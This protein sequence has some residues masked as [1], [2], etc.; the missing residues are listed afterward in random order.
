MF[1]DQISVS[2][3]IG[4]GSRL[5]ASTER[6]LFD[7]LRTADGR[8]PHQCGGLREEQAVVELT[9]QLGGPGHGL[10]AFVDKLVVRESGSNRSLHLCRRSDHAASFGHRAVEV[11]DVFHLRRQSHG[12]TGSGA[13]H[14]PR[15]SYLA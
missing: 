15:R 1:G 14:S 7:A 5:P 11:F 13:V 6:S 4:I 9:A 3:Q 10:V 12:A 8:W 2:F